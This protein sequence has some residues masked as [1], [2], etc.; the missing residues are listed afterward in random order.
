MGESEFGNISWVYY[1]SGAYAV[2]A[3]T[4]LVFTTN[5]LGRFKKAMESLNEEIASDD[6]NGKL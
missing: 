4:L 2:V 5:S 3:L 6:K 1:V